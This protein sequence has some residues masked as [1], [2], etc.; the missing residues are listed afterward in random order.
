L[1]LRLRGAGVGAERKNFG[2]TTLLKTLLTDLY[3]LVPRLNFDKHRT[4]MFSF[5]FILFVNNGLRKCE[6][7]HCTEAESMG[8]Y[9]GVDYNLTLCPLQSRHQHIYHGEPYAKVD[10]NPLPESTLS[11]SP[12]LLIWLRYDTVH[13]LAWW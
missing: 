13:Q 7:A 10:L 2:S 1:D 3:L 6:N 11:P 8:P 12:G 5:L 4:L 9:A